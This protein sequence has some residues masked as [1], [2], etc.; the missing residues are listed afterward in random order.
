MNTE[1]WDWR[2]PCPTPKW[3]HL[4]SSWMV[5]QDRSTAHGDRG[6]WQTM[7]KACASLPACNQLEAVQNMALY[8]WSSVAYHKVQEAGSHHTGV[9]LA[10]MTLQGDGCL[11]LPR[12]RQ[13][14]AGIAECRVP[15]GREKGNTRGPGTVTRC[16][17]WTT[18]SE[19]MQ[20]VQQLISFYLII[21]QTESHHPSPGHSPNTCNSQGLDLVHGGRV[22]VVQLSLPNPPTLGVHWQE[23]EIWDFNPVT[24]MWLYPLCQTPTLA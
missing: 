3:Q 15:G 7:A 6:G 22:Q 16:L 21:R 20:D 19:M 5:T 14:S 23:V 10:G 17:W 4:L 24:L 1:G 9:Y 13:Y 12:H 8:I 18:L 2:F 11:K